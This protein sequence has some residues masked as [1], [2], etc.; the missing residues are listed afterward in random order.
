MSQSDYIQRKKLGNELGRGNQS[1][2]QH[3]LN[4]MDYIQ[5]K[6]YS[7]ENTIVNSSKRYNQLIPTGS[8]DIFNMEVANSSVCPSFN[9]CPTTSRV[10]H[11]LVD[12]IAFNPYVSGKLPYINSYTT[13]YTPNQLHYVKHTTMHKCGGCCYDASNSVA[14]KPNEN[15]WVSACSNARKRRL[16][17]DCSMN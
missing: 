7:L 4:A 15:T 12:S 11:S 10:N 16:I 5:Y 1:K 9:M 8:K 6:Q 13:V 2:L 3:V 14:N 17:C